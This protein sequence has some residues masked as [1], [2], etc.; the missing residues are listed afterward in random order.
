MIRLQRQQSFQ[1]TRLSSE[2]KRK[3]HNFGGGT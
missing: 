3:V 2:L 1:T